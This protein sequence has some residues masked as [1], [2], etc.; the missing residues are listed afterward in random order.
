M[1]MMMKKKKGHGDIKDKNIN[2]EKEIKR[3]MI[4]I[5]KRSVRG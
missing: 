3:E 5:G 4:K 1:M 2:N